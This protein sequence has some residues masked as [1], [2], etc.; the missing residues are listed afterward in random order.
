MLNSLIRNVLI[1]SNT[2]D[3]KNFTSSGFTALT[4]LDTYATLMF[5]KSS[6]NA[7][8]YVKFSN[9]LIKGTEYVFATSDG[10][11]TTVHIPWGI[12]NNYMQYVKNFKTSDMRTPAAY[13]SFTGNTG[14]YFLDRTNW[15]GEQTI[16]N[17][18][19]SGSSTDSYLKY[20]IAYTGGAVVFYTDDSA[21]AI[22]LG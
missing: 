16:Q 7:G 21:T 12:Q 11:G 2:F 13:N 4:T 15:I 22:T 1:D 14:T 8:I 10:T 3:A 5:L 17:G 6:A 9:N 18:L 19:G 20:N